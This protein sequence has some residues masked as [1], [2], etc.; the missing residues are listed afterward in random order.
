MKRIAIVGAGP[1]GLE[2]A[3][4]ARRLGHT[5]TVYERENVADSIRAW[6]HVAMFSPW[7]MNL[8]PLG[9]GELGKTGW[10][11]PDPSAC[12]TGREYRDRYLVPLA[13]SLGAA[14]Q[15]G[16]EAMGIA[17]A[18]LLK[19]ETAPGGRQSRPFRILLKKRSGQ[20]S[21]AEADAVLDASGVFNTP[22]FLGDGGLPAVGERVLRKAID[23][24]VPD[25]LGE[26]RPR[27]A[28]KAVLVVGDG[29]SAATAIVSL[30]RLQKEEP[31]T[32]VVWAFRSAGGDPVA[33]VPQDP[34]AAR[35]G[36]IAEANR[37][38]RERPG[39]LQ[40]SPGGM[41]TSIDRATDRFRV[42]FRTPDGKKSDVVVDRIVAN[43]GFRP[44]HEISREIQASF[45][46]DSEAATGPG[47]APAAH[48]E[49]GFHVIGQK[50]RGRSGSFLIDELKADI[51][52]VFR[53]IE[54]KPDLDLYRT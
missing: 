15:N 54:E 37:I 17:R 41:V 12:P 52:E 1:A 49:P 25:I 30:I 19:W 50:A 5:V 47:G 48:P 46:C 2:A 51:R 26:D 53:M 32:R 38:A 7:R 3:I 27:F 44:T 43:V 11:A 8:T 22:A 20:E 16:F 28:G 13:T 45:A 34:L 24:Q 9:A 40:V 6:G 31:K 23:Y 21:W 42:H 35:A 36:L 29:L 4:Y 10:A 18:G 33:A 14:V 39:D